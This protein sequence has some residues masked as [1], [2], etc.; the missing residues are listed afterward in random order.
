MSTAATAVPGLRVPL[1]DLTPQWRQIEAAALPELKA[2]FMSSAFCLG[3]WVQRFEA[4]VAD[5]LGVG[6]AIGV[7][8]GTSALHLAMIAAG[9]GPGDEVIVPANTFVATAWAV[10]YVGA[11]PVFCDVEAGSWTIDPGDAKRRITPATK[12][13]VPVHLYGQPAD[14]EAVTALAE[15]YNLVVIEDAAQA[16]GTVYR[17]QKVGGHGLLGCFSFYPSKSLGAAGEGGLVTTNDATLATRVRRLRS[18]G[19]V[20]RYVHGELGFN[21]RMEGIQGLILGEKLKHLDDWIAERRHIARRYL[22]GLSGTPVE[23]PEVSNGDHTWYSF[24]IHSPERDR[25]RSEL[26]A[27]G[28]ETGLHYPVPLHRQPCFDHLQIDRSSFPLADRNARECLTLPLFVGMSM[29]QIDYVIDE[30]RRFFT[31]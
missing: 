3:P 26:A 22:E 11:I 23:L 8:S 30:V 12:A 28:I 13:I 19:E 4:A 31:A 5:Y 25:L 27:R 24:V 17:G 10:L 6:H 15:R 7:N 1:T 9:I 18:H 16:I 20:E 2:L 21:Y 14:L 29:T